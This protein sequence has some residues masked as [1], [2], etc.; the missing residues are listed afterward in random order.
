[1]SRIRGIQTPRLESHLDGTLFIFAHQDVPGIIGSVGNVFGC[2]KVNIAQMTVGRVSKT[3]GGEAIGVLQLDGT[4]SK[5]AI[6]E[7]LSLP[8]IEAVDLIQL[9]ESGSLPEWLSQ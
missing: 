9:P 2:Q 4:P 8:G 1:M 7:V 3:P 6:D 5:E